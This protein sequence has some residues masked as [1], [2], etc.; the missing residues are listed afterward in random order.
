M[1]FYD[2]IYSGD[3]L[4]E[5]EKKNLL[6]ISSA[7]KNAVEQN[8]YFVLLSSSEVFDRSLDRMYSERNKPNS[9]KISSK[10]LI[11]SEQRVLEYKYGFVARVQD[12]FSSVVASI[13]KMLEVDGR[14]TL[15]G[16]GLWILMDQYVNILI[17]YLLFN[18]EKKLFHICSP[19]VFTSG[20]I[21][22]ILKEDGANINQDQ[23][24]FSMN[25]YRGRICSEILHSLPSYKDLML[26]N[27]KEVIAAI[28]SRKRDV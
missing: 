8:E 28:S 4:K 7:L 26:K 11:E 16:E 1:I 21:W 27:K 10:L 24:D 12:P 6:D 2:T 13:D 15:A 23:Y 18:S 3:D 14:P 20:M 22:L 5:A 19:Y 25:G 17:R 9:K